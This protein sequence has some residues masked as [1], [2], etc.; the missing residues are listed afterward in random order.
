MNWVDLVQ[1]HWPGISAEDANDVLWN[2]TCFP[3][4]DA[5]MIEEQVKQAYIKGKGNVSEAIAIVEDEMF[6]EF[7]RHKVMEVLKNG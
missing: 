3:M 2:A 6:E 7:K 1:Q 4:G 5:A